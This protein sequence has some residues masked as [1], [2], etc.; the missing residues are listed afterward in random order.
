MI[1]KG[2]VS[3]ED[4]KKATEEFAPARKVRVELTFDV[5]GEKGFDALNYIAEKVDAKVKEMLGQKQA[6]VAAQAATNVADGI[7]AAAEPS[8]KPIRKKAEVLPPVDNFP[9]DGQAAKANEPSA[10]ETGLDDGILG[11]ELASAAGAM[12][13]KPVDVSDKALYDFVVATNAKVKKPKEITALIS[14]YCPAD[15]VPPSLKRVPEAKRVAFINEV[16]AFV[17]SIKAK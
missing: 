4:G 6:S 17:E 3:I 9:L 16:K 5:D 14:K 2:T 10:D 12:P 11:N 15:G 1:T 8:K 13:E 7:A